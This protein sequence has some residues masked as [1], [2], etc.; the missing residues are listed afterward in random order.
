MT[1][2]LQ[3]KEVQIDKQAMSVYNLLNDPYDRIPLFPSWGNNT[4][5]YV[6]S[7]SQLAKYKAQQAQAEILELEKLIDGHKASI[8]SLEKTI[9]VLRK[10]LPEEKQAT[11]PVD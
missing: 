3:N 7:D 8:E 9:S 4:S 10:E 1:E 2:I 6:I 5:V 11:E